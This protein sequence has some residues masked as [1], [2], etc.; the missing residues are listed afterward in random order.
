MPDLPEK[1]PPGR[2]LGWRK[3]QTMTSRLPPMRIPTHLE[4][5]LK[6]EAEKRGLNV[7]DMA[8]MLLIEAMRS[9]D[10]TNRSS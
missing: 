6:A 8:R 10:G 7:V 1:K 5:W 3:A 2:P 4:D 9:Q